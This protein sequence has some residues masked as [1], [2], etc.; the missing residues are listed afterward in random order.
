[1]SGKRAKKLR[2]E[3][4]AIY[5]RSPAGPTIEK[6]GKR[7]ISFGPMK[8]VTREEEI[9]GVVRPVTRFIH[10]ITRPIFEVKVDRPSEWRRWKKERGC[11]W[12]F[13]VR[14]G[15]RSRFEPEISD[16]R[17]VPATEFPIAA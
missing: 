1:M 8:S 14:M 16:P 15:W 10:S 12:A 5:G 11:R 17:I 7:E 2:A 4:R 9:K 6:Q 13:E 3:F